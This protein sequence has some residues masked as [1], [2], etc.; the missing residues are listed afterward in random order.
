[1]SLSMEIKKKFENFTL[2]VKLEKEN[3]ILGLLGAS[4]SGKSVTLQCIAGLLTP[5]EGKICLNGRTLFDSEKGIN[6]PPQKRRVGYLFQNYALFPH[7]TVEK[8]ILCGLS[9]EKDRKKRRE[10]MQEAAK[11]F[12]IEPF[13]KKYPG[14]LSGGQQQRTALARI[15]VSEPELLL[16][17]EP[18]SALDAYL[19][20]QLQIQVREL[21]EQFGRDTIL[22]SHS[23]DEVYQLCSRLALLEQ[24]EI[25][26]CGE[27]KAV[28]QN[29]G[30]R[31][32]A[33]L[34]GCKNIA[35]ARK[36]GEY[37]VEVPAWGVRFGTAEPVRDGLVAVGVWAHHF[38]PDE[39]ENR[40]PVVCSGK[41]E[42]PFET[43]VLF[44]YGEKERGTGKLWWRISGE[45]KSE[46]LPEHL[47]VAAEH[48]LLLYH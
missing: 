16:L 14:E 30:S 9:A 34:T 26:E 3:G 31:M 17:D 25:L 48:L 39:R 36:T 21:L 11:L 13:L 43:T 1:M 15:L 8:N 2:Q 35:A 22:V 4:G 5:D 44:Q 7:M 20:D 6:L 12:Q 40:Y 33:V 45:Q 18:F 23:R 28:F 29:P 38:S 42:G 10:K 24:G 47:G 46:K 27:T 41:M 19:R 32:G 37:E